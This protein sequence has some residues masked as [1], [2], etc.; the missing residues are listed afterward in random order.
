M[1]NVIEDAQKLLLDNRAEWI[2]RYKNYSN[3]IDKNKDVINKIRQT[4]REWSPLRFYIST[5]NVIK[6]SKGLLLDV[7]Y[8]GQSVAILTA[9]QDD[10]TIST[11]SDK[12]DTKN[13]NNL[14]DFNCNIK[15][16]DDKWRSEKVTAFRK[17]FSTKPN[18][19]KVKNNKGNEEHNVENLLLT[20][21]SK[22]KGKDKQI[23]GIQPI[24][25]SNIRFA[26][27]TPI[28]ASKHNEPLKYSGKGGGIDIFA[29]TGNGNSTYLTV[30][31]VKDENK[32]N[33]PPTDALKQAIQYSVF[34]RE[35]LRS[36][37]GQDWYKIFGFKGKIPDKLK[38]RVACAMPDDIL[39]KSFAKRTYSIGSDEIECHYIYFKYDGEQLSDFQTSLD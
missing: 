39:D 24:R 22:R 26:M 35:L 4:F 20:E 23:L 30:I 10:V 37:C 11:E 32:P 27:P 19:I 1:K 18:R 33:E 7:R 25:I 29:R 5:T 16:N 31:E 8:R 12:E 2:D 36:E 21:F 15:L 14:R 9:T 38:I 34:I 17:Y 6:S 28:S 13:N 3:K